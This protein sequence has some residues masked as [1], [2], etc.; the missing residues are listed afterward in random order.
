MFYR[1][2]VSLVISRT[3]NWFFMIINILVLLFA[4]AI[5]LHAEFL[6]R[7]TN[8]ANVNV[9]ITDVCDAVATTNTSP[10]QLPEII[11]NGEWPAIAPYQTIELTFNP[12]DQGAIIVR[13]EPT[14][15][16][17]IKI[18]YSP[19]LREN[20]L[21]I[22]TR[23][24]YISKYP[25]NQIPFCM[26]NTQSQFYSEDLSCISLPVEITIQ[27]DGQIYCNGTFVI[28][29]TSDSAQLPR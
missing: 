3:R 13:L 5:S 27:N 12:D 21:G 16:W 22:T 26:P 25:I 7:I 18:G 17:L 29:N 6:I 28:D 20:E 19:Y 8:H 14:D 9:E 10:L 15:P 1:L 11:Y 23:G 24:I 2:N 4:C